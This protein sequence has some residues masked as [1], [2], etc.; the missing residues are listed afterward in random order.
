MRSGSGRSWSTG[1]V[2]SVGRE[3]REG[4]GFGARRM[5]ARS[6]DGGG[7]MHAFHFDQVWHLAEPIRMITFLMMND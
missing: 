6:S 7:T 4:G 5:G 3:E 1:A 2:S